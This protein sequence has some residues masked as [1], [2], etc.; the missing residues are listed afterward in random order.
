MV[1]TGANNLYSMTYVT[2]RLVIQACRGLSARWLAQGPCD[3][4]PGDGSTHTLL[5]M[6]PSG[7]RWQRNAGGPPEPEGRLRRRASPGRS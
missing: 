2:W 7:R 3:N 6:Q 1:A 5:G 4:L